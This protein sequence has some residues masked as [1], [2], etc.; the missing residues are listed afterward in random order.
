[1]RA[2]ERERPIAR[3]RQPH[4][5]DARTLIRN[6]TTTS[7][8][9][10]LAVAA[11][12]LLDVSIASTYGAGVTSD[13]F[14]VAASSTDYLG[15]GVPNSQK[16]CLFVP[17]SGQDANNDG[18]D[19]ACEGYIE[20]PIAQD[21][22]NRSDQTHWGTASD[23]NAWGG[24]ASNNSVFSIGNNTGVASGQSGILSGALGPIAT[25]ERALM[26]AKTSSFASGT[27]FD[28]LLR[29]TDNNNW[30]KAYLDGSHLVIRR[31]Q[32]GTNTQIASVPFTAAANTLYTIRFQV[33]GELLSAK[34]WPA[35]GSEPADWMVS[36]DD[37]NLASGK[38]GIGVNNESGS[39]ITFT[40]FA[41]YAMN[42][43]TPPAPS[44]PDNS[45]L[46]ALDTFQ[47]SNQT[48]WGTASDG[49]HTWDGDASSNNKFSISSNFGKVSGSS[50]II[51]GA[52]GPSTTDTEVDATLSTTSFNGTDFGVL[53][54]Y[55]DNNN[56]YKA[57]LDGSNIV[58]RRMQ[59]GTNTQIASASFPA[60]IATPYN[61]RFKAVGYTLSAK[62]WPSN[63][64]EPSD[65]TVTT[66]DLNL[67]AGQSGV[68]IMNSG[69]NTVSYDYFASYSL[70]AP[71]TY[72]LDMFDR[73]NQ[74]HWGTADD[75]FAWVADAATASNFA[76]TG[77]VGAVS[78]NSGII[79]GILGTG[80]SD[81]QVM[82]TA[83]TNSFNGTDYG[84]LLRYTNNNNW[85]KAYIDGSN[86]IIRR[87]LNGNNSVIAQSS[88]SASANTPYTIKFEA[89]GSTLEAKAWAATGSEP[90]SWM[91]S[92]TDSNF[93]TGYAG[94]GIYNG[95]GHTVDYISFSAGQP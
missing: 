76:I 34:V 73:A 72:A 12:L 37:T 33:T 8:A 35:S 7:V 22:F 91:V 50:G 4:R 2:R 77:N 71:S 17:Q 13:A 14:F 40:S 86:L 79:N 23:S 52:L 56:W 78:G 48:H 84:V 95:G 20:A 30:Y 27:D 53:L 36:V 93:T 64:S 74:T 87:M 67:Y 41:C 21:T 94:V 82:S 32:N 44:A 51:N 60:S 10:A 58:I 61:I 54:R 83:S 45:S 24:D 80:F 55:T 69:G 11:G 63:S 90:S 81:G 18:I 28:V 68:G 89:S 65:W 25:D 70:A 62:V 3:K 46:A 26:T 31:M 19:D 66:T 15:D 42:Q 88:F 38:C 92:T 1:V 57:Y 39:T 49:S 85:Y 16:T 43:Q 59:N 75:G 29:Y 5:G 47:R 9:A 6:S